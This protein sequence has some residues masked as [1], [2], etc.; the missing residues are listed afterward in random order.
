MLGV[1]FWG[2]SLRLNQSYSRTSGSRVINPFLS[3][4]KWYKRAIFSVVPGL[5]IFILNGS[6]LITLISIPI[7]SLTL[8]LAVSSK[9]SGSLTFPPQ[10]F[11][12]SS[13]LLLFKRTLPSSI[14][15][16]LEAVIS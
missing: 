5:F 2:K 7:S 12:K 14:I 13:P 8:L 6:G 15:T 1:R 11:Q 3:A 16:G 9:F 10:N 4:K